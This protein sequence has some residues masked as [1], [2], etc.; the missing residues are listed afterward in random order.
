MVFLGVAIGF[1][2]CWVSVLF[3]VPLVLSEA[4]ASVVTEGSLV[5]SFCRS[6]SGRKKWR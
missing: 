2:L 1:C 4:E 3:M 5:E 6:S